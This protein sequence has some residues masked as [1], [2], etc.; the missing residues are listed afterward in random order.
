MLGYYSAVFRISNIINSGLAR[1]ENTNED[2]DIWIMD[3]TNQNQIDFLYTNSNIQK[4]NITDI[5][6]T[7]DVNGRKWL[8]CAKETES[9]I[10][11]NKNKLPKL[12]LFFNM[13]IILLVLMILIY[14]K[15]E[16]EQY[17][18]ILEINSKLIAMEEMINNI[19]HQW[20]QPLSLIKIVN[21]TNEYKLKAIN[22]ED[23]EILK[24]IENKNINI[25]ILKMRLF[26]KIMLVELKMK[27]CIRYLIPM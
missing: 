27:F 6:T 15:R 25:V 18:S 9:F 5:T 11:K 26:M 20:L 16:K 17:K 1:D 12:I 4:N 22:F 13:I 19:A 23:E 14:I 2:L 7:I 10:S 8:I 21:T 24:N 3:A